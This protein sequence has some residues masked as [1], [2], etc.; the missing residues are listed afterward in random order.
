MRKLFLSAALALSL[1]GVGH[2]WSG[3]DYNEGAFVEIEQDNLVR[4][5]ETIEFYDF[6]TGQ[7]HQ[8]DVE[9]IQRYGNS[10]EVDLYDH[11]SGE[12]RTLEMDS[13]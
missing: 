11:N 13:E 6:S 12:Y 3:Y 4:S 9:S 10:V 8:A 2:A 1:P 5:G 7:Y